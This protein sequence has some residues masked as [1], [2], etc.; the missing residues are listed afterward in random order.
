M[1][2]A[3]SAALQ[4]AVY[5]ALIGDATVAG[6]VGDRV[7]DAVPRGPLPDLYVA[8]GP[9]RAKDASDKSGRGAWHGFPVSVITEETGFQ[10]AKEVAAAICDVLIDAPLALARGRLVALHFQRAEARREKS[11]R[12][13]I[14]LTFE[15]RVEDDM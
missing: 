2:Y 6:L 15:A 14:D 11:G 9:E 5:Q 12:R 13:R 4:Q 3:V 10:P 7:Y 8:L 1:T